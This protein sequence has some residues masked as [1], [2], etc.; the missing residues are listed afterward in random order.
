VFNYTQIKAI[1]VQKVKVT[2][3]PNPLRKLFIDSIWRPFFTQLQVK[4][5]QVMII[6]VMMIE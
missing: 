6:E 5:P 3:P 4:H 1:V 2:P